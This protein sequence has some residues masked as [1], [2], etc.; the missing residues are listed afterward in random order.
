MAHTEGRITSQ[1]LEQVEDQ[2]ILA[3][4]ELQRE[5][6]IDVYTDGKYRRGD[7][8]TEPAKCEAI[9]LR[10]NSGIYILHLKLQI[11]GRRR[12]WSFGPW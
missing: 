5:V 3:A 2:A 8:R 7:F 12:E 4:F 9:D 10:R 6:G 11:E 1:Q